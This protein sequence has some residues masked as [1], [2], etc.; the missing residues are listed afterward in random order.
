[1]R[2]DRTGVRP[3][4]TARLG[5]GRR[6]TTRVASPGARRRS[7]LT[8]KVEAGENLRR[9][10]RPPTGS[11]AVSVPTRPS[12]LAPGVRN[13]ENPLLERLELVLEGLDTVD[14]LIDLGALDAAYRGATMLQ[15]ELTDIRREMGF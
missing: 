11:H 2:G 8:F 1:M 6:S 4:S 3:D 5:R 9:G 7:R 12:S 10:Y 15:G 13:R 14:E